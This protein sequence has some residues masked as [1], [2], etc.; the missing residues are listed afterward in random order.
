MSF[1]SRSQSK[2]I[3]SALGSVAHLE[4]MHSYVEKGYQWIRKYMTMKPPQEQE[5]FLLYC[6]H[7][8][9]NAKEH[10]FLENNLTIHTEGT[11]NRDLLIRMLAIFDKP[12]TALSLTEK[13]VITRHRN[14]FDQVCL[15]HLSQLGQQQYRK[16]TYAFVN[17][18]A[19][20][21]LT[22]GVLNFIT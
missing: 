14:D 15:K 22:L 20:I 12:T 10:G 13:K 4:Q 19:R 8:F 18:F 11:Q 21:A 17:E 5:L 6:Q 16:N 9:D 2:Q 1:F 3:D 7:W